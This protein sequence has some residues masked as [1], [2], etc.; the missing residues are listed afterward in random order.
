M[1]PFS[2]EQFMS[3][4]V[5]YNQ[6]IW[7]AQI[8]AEVLGLAII[9]AIWRQIRWSGNLA[10]LAL[11]VMW[12]W[13]GL[14]YHF[15]FFS[16]INSAAFIFAAFFVLQGLLFL[17]AA[18]LNDPQFGKVPPIRACAG[19]FLIFYAILLYP[20]IGV[21]LGH[22]LVE[23]PSFGVTPCPLTIFSFGVLLLA[24]QRVPIWLLTIPLLWSVVGGSAA[25][26]LSVPQDWMLLASGIASLIL[27]KMTIGN[28][29]E[30]AK[31]AS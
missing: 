27:M 24:K 12:L 13:T 2:R 28:R 16:G 25:L 7:P 21:L 4:F 6:A 22:S 3:V 10:Y 18:A 17:L 11:A 31:G 30:P 29:G 15:A 19:G 20:L 1:L 26:L 23:L 8:V 14:S 9:Y 5:I